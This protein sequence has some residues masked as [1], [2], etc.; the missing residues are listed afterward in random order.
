MQH[1]GKFLPESIKSIAKILY[2]MVL[3]AHNGVCL[4]SSRITITHKLYVLAETMELLQGDTLDLLKAGHHG[5][6]S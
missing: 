2:Q 3:T 1:S 5:L 4:F 6:K